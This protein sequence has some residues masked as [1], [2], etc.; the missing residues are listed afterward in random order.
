MA[1][2]MTL[3]EYPGVT[4][5]S[6]PALWIAAQAAPWHLDFGIKGTKTFLIVLLYWIP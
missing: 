5:T 6:W 3:S 1:R 4:E 2:F